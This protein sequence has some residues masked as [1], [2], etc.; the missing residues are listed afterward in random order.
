MEVLFIGSVITSLLVKFQIAKRYLIFHVK[1]PNP[2]HEFA[3]DG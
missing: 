3:P 2:K 1:K